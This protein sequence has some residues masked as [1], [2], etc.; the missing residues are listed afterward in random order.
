MTATSRSSLGPLRAPASLTTLVTEAIRD[1]IVAR[2]LLPGE[3][4][5]ESSLAE[6]LQVSKTP[7]REALLRLESIGLV[8]PDGARGGRI[9]SL[10]A[11][12]I[13]HAFEVRAALE[14]HAARLAAIHASTASK[15]KIAKLARGSR[16][17]AQKR[18]VDGYRGLDRSFHLGVVES[19]DNP[20]LEGLIDDAITLTWTLRSRDVPMADD[21]VDCARQHEDIASA[22]SAGDQ[23]SAADAMFEHLRTV[24][25]IVLNAF[26]GEG[27]DEESTLPLAQRPRG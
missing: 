27:D 22:I 8:E 26:Q 9:V 16:L 12:T 23:T 17:A 18:D 10:S 15:A 5:T 6:Q 25:R 3:R 14:V 4:V 2:R 20:R 21:S 11:D 7:V 1:A 13:R 19:I 24:W